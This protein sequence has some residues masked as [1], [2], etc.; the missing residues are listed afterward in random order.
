MVSIIDVTLN[1]CFV[2]IIF[3][4]VVFIIIIKI[5]KKAGLDKHDVH[6]LLKP[7]HSH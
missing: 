2:I 1:Y 4:I 5:R 6:K 3:I 7:P